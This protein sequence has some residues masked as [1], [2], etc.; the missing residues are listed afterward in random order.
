MKT[1]RKEAEVLAGI[2]AYL[3]IR[4]D[5]FFWRQNNFAGAIGKDYIRAERGV[6]DILC[7]KQGLLYGIEAKREKG[8]RVSDEQQRWGSNLVASGGIYIVARSV[9]DVENIL[10]PIGPRIGLVKRKRGYPR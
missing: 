6:S 10:G 3:A 8:G 2:L 7:V 4:G 9:A 5:V 1:N